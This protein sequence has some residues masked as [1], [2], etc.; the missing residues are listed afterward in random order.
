MSGLDFSSIRVPQPP[1]S[2]GMEDDPATVREAFFKNPD[3]L[4]LLKQNNPSL[5][6]ALLS[7]NLGKCVASNHSVAGDLYYHKIIRGIYI[8]M[9][10]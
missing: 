1:M 7:G 4:A 6:D 10:I 2:V 8:L 5:A 3:Q 9:C